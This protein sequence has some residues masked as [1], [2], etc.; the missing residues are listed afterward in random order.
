MEHDETTPPCKVCGADH[1]GTYAPCYLL[2]HGSYGFSPQH[3]CEI[4]FL[5][6]NVNVKIFEAPNGQLALVVD[7]RAQ[8]NATMVMHEDCVET[9]IDRVIALSDLDG[10]EDD[11]LEDDYHWPSF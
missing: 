5:A 3:G 8:S 6:P 10:M 1:V 4:F 9:A 11:E 7:V 2:L